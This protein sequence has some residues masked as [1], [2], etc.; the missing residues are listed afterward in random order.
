MPFFQHDGL[1]FDKCDEQ[2]ATAFSVYCG[3]SIMHSLV[4]KRVQKAEARHKLSQELLT[5]HTKVR[6]DDVETLLR[7]MRQ[8]ADPS[9]GQPSPAEFAS[10]EYNPRETPRA[11]TVPLSMQMFIELRFVDTFK[12]RDE[13]LARF[14]LTV[15]R[16]YRDTIPY[17][18][19]THAF[20][21]AHFAYTLLSNLAL[22]EDGY[23]TQL[24]ALSLLI[25]CFCHDL[26]H[27]GTNNSYQVEVK[28]PLARLYSSEG[29]VN[30]RHHLSQAICLLNE[31]N[32]K[33]LDGL[34]EP[35]F[36]ECIDSLRHLILATDIAH[37]FSIL[38]QLQLLTAANV[39]SNKRLLMSLL[40]TCCDLSDQVR[41]W[42]TNKEVA[43]LVYSEFFAQGDMERE[44]G[45]APNTMMDRRRACVP[46]LQIEFIDTCVRPTFAVLAGLFEQTA[47][48]VET[49][50]ENRA[51]WEQKRADFERCG[52]DGT[53]G[54]KSPTS[55]SE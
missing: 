17:H 48:F 31:H 33:I 39:R 51:H 2:I 44:M 4:H 16:G 36:K 12:M 34:N 35:E 46:Q 50:D 30:E 6:D 21:V 20:A 27:R 1:H 37:H 13:K 25:A 28:S 47:A 22:V 40:M 14:L 26:D 49:I 54:E 5:Y 8:P 41:A 9:S 29:S 23:L 24:D 43:N 15:R 10:L 38:G 32:S 53:E 11:L 55:A 45:L 7:T 42:S 18:N 19:W 3:I 52:A